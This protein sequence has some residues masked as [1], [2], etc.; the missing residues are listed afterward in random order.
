MLRVVICFVGQCTRDTQWH[1]HRL[2]WI[3]MVRKQFFT[4]KLIITHNSW[5]GWHNCCRCRSSMLIRNIVVSEYSWS[6]RYSAF[7]NIFDEFG[8]TPR[9]FCY[10]SYRYAYINDLILSR[11]TA[12]SSRPRELHF[13]CSVQQILYTKWCSLAITLCQFLELVDFCRLLGSQ[14]CLLLQIW[15]LTCSPHLASLLAVSYFN[16]RML[17]PY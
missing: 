1:R 12:T 10:H 15:I 9:C 16:A 8:R 5:C 4:L 13:F 14:S 17:L 2:V 3:C 7:N 11:S 6:I